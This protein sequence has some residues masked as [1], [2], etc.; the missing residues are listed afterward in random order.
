MP[1]HTGT[2]EGP[3]APQNTLVTVG[4]PEPWHRL[5]TG[6]GVS[7]LGDGQKSPRQPHWS[8]GLEKVTFTGTFPQPIPGSVTGSDTAMP[9]DGSR[10]NSANISKSE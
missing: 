2:Q 6:G 4:V 8:R 3:S 7:S 1:G 10:N 5:P 9:T